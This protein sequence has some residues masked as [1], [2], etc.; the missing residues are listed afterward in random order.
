MQ[1]KDKLFTTHYYY[2]YK[3]KTQTHRKTIRKKRKG[4][5]RNT[6]NDANVDGKKEEV[7]PARTSIFWA[8]NLRKL[9]APDPPIISRFNEISDVGRVGSGVH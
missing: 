1:D 4:K 2:Y 5:I 9:P 6:D 8:S 7:N 3:T